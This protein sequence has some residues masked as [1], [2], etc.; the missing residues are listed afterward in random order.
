MAKQNYNL[1][2]PSICEQSIAGGLQMAGEK[3]F[4]KHLYRVE[5]YRAGI[6]LLVDS[7]P[8]QWDDLPVSIMKLAHDVKRISDHAANLAEIAKV[9]A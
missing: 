5:V 7:A 3:H 9:K 6:R 1:I 2:V 4:R 8:C